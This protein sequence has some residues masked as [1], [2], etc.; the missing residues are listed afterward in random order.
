M[1]TGEG[2][3]VWGVILWSVI[4]DMAKKQETERKYFQVPLPFSQN[5][6]KMTKRTW[7]GFNKR[8]VVDTGALSVEM[9]ISTKEA[10]YL[11]PSEKPQRYKY[12]LPQ[13]G[14]AI[15]I[16]GFGNALIWFYDDETALKTKIHYEHR[17]I[18]GAYN[19]EEA[20]PESITNLEPKCLVQFNHYEN[21]LNPVESAYT[22][23]ILIFP[24]RLSMDCEQSVIEAH[25]SLG[26]ATINDDTTITEYTNSQSPYTPPGGSD[27][28]KYWKNT[29]NGLIYRWNGSTWEAYVPPHCP[30]IKYAT[31]H[32]SRL[33]GV[34][35]GMIYASGFNDYSNWNLDTIDDYNESNAWV[36]PTQSNVQAESDFMGITTFSN[37]VICFKGNF[38]HEIY[39]TKNPF[40][41]HDIYAEGCVNNKTIQ[42]VEG[43][44]IFVS[45]DGVK[46]YTGSNPRDISYSLNETDFSEESVAGSDGRNYY[47]FYSDGKNGKKFYTYDTWTRSWSEQDAPGS[48]TWVNSKVVGIVRNN[49]GLY[50]MTNGFLTDGNE[51]LIYKL[52]TGDYDHDWYC[53]T[54]TTTNA[55]VDIKH[56]KKIQFLAD[57]AAGANIKVHILYDNEDFDGMTTAE[58][59]ARLVYAYTN[60]GQTEVQKTI[61][62]KPRMTANYGFKVRI[63]GHGFVRIY[64]M[65]MLVENGGDLY[66]SN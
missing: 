27:T 2:A 7:Q 41:V 23:K 57:V 61:R 48:E 11:T 26:I 38:M 19:K 28:S 1:V 58:K 4:K 44:L 30:P 56:I 59:N 63:S 45:P 20:L 10:P 55:S 13:S 40:R 6:G 17:V 22:K 33:F 36:S 53:E 29:Y 3:A 50:C 32:L 16:H 47:L 8:N 42:E 12:T 35:G 46:I 34:G 31:V 62:V 25:G 24:D 9:N 64:T 52:D 54:D 49:N 18:T 66:V 5:A 43:Q 65:E 51:F 15:S 14:R 21:P 37:H 60:T 39:N